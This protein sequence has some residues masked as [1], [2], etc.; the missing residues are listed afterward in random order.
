MVG[1]A[2]GGA[3][4]QMA[5]RKSKSTAAIAP[6]RRG[7]C[8]AA[9]ARDGGVTATFTASSRNARPMRRIGAPSADGPR[10]KRR[11][12]RKRSRR[13]AC[14][15]KFQVPASGKSNGDLWQDSEDAPVGSSSGPKSRPSEIC[16]SVECTVV[17]MMAGLGWGEPQEGGS[18]WRSC[19]S[20]GGGVRDGRAGR[21]PGSRSRARGCGSIG[22]HGMYER[23]RK[24][25]RGRSRQSRLCRGKSDSPVCWRLQGTPSLDRIRRD[26]RDSG[27]GGA[28]ALAAAE[29]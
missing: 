14:G 27:A 15:S 1:G 9:V 7:C 19:R 23:W 5:T 25:A 17:A 6:Q 8:S 4:R 22:A 24:W 3:R 2:A 16:R 18:S 28:A 26:R 12:Y 21:R 20:V 11:A 29:T 10:S 13:A